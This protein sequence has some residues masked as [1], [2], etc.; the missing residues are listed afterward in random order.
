MKKVIRSMSIL[1]GCGVL[2]LTSCD[3]DEAVLEQTVDQTTQTRAVEDLG[4]FIPKNADFAAIFQENRMENTEAF[5]VNANEDIT[6]TTAGG[7]VLELRANSLENMEGA[8]VEGEVTIFFNGLTD[9]GQMIVQDRATSGLNEAGDG[10]AALITGGE[11]FIEVQ[12]GGEALVLNAAMAVNVPVVDPD[13]DMRMFAEADRTGDD[14][15]WVLDEERAL[16]VVE[17]GGEG[18]GGTFYRYEILPDLGDQWRGWN[19]DKFN[20]DNCP[21]GPYS[22]VSVKV[23]VG[24]NPTNTEAYMIPCATNGQ[25][26]NFDNWNSATN[27][28]EEHGGLVCEGLCVHFIVVTNVGGSLEYAIHTSVT[29]NPGAHVEVFTGPFASIT[30]NALVVLINSLP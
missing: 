26:S 19:I 6:V 7:V 17:R 13:P 25:I 2:L 27:S 8:I 11:F 23:P 16:D 30:P 4:E 5:V 10:V 22:F 18:G 9:D 12:Q 28:F 20:R 15:V 3:K 24:Y 14:L 21:G 1:L 29:I